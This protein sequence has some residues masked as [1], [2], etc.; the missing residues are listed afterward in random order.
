MNGWPGGASVE[1]LATA[2][3]S[4]ASARSALAKLKE[5]PTAQ[6]ITVAKGQS[7]AG[8]H[9]HGA[10]AGGLRQGVLDWR[11]RCVAP[12]VGNCRQATI[13][14]E[15]AVANYELATEGPTESQLKSAEAQVVQAEGA[16]QRLL[17]SPT[18]SDLAVAESQVVQAQSTLDR[19]LDNPSEQQLAI[20]RQQVRQSEIAVEQAELGL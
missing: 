1:D 19:L 10:G 2:E 13:N 7:R 12:V 4:L 20:A 9:L 11:G 8:S 17:D 18:E 6:S 15:A 14:Y 16:L 3:A 5:G